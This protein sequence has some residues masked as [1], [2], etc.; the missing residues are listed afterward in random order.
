MKDRQL[1]LAVLAQLEREKTVSIPQLAALLGLSEE[2]VYDAL[3]T[4]VFAYD[5]ASI[6]LDLHD[7]Y[8]TLDTSGTDRLLRLTQTE[9]D[10]LVDA[11]E[12]AGFSADDELV[13]ALLHTKSVLQDA[14]GASKPRLQVV[15]ESGSS[16]V[17]QAL[18]AACEDAEHHLLRIRYQGI[19]DT[20]PRTRI[21]EPV[22]IF[23]ED[24]HRYL[25][26]FCHEAQGWRSF[27]IDRITRV[28]GLDQSFSPRDDIP[29]PSVG[30]AGTGRRARIALDAGCPLPSWR[31]MRVTSR[32]D[33]GSCI[34]SLDWTGSSWLPRHVVAL[35][36]AARV[37]EPQELKDAC[38]DCARKLLL[39]ADMHE[40]T[41]VSLLDGNTGAK[42]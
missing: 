26:A 41:D 27:R 6:R 42:E 37:L 4:L 35:M 21:I 29:S 7:A 32:D 16:D 31:G 36:G 13:C 23:S 9:A 39:S 20:V 14:Q 33:D 5:A 11:L 17:F 18:A 10:A 34:I 12:K 28:S 3:E 38:T 1:L 22:R 25:Q 8:A 15:A 19:D 24:G 40:D 2:A 30:M